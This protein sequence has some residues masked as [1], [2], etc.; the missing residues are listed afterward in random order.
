MAA[1][2]PAFPAPVVAVLAFYSFGLIHAGVSGQAAVVLFLAERLGVLEDAVRKRL[3]EFYL[4]AEDQSGSKQG[5]KR[6]HFDATLA[7]APL[8]RWILSLWEG[9][10]LALAIDATNL[11]ERFHVLCVSVVVRGLAIP[12]AWKVLYGGV[13]ESGTPTGA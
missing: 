10:H 8:L 2:F 9:R 6:K 5:Q 3:R 1:R 4:D 13:E 11:G 7:F 12:V